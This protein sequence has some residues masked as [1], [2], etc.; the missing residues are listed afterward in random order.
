M[1]PFTCRAVA[2][3]FDMLD[4]TRGTDPDYLRKLVRRH[5]LPPE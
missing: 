4:G 5:R 2:M 3:H 1:P